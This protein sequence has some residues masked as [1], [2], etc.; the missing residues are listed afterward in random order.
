MSLCIPEAVENMTIKNLRKFFKLMGFEPEND[1]SIRDFF[2]C[3]PETEEYLRDLWADESRYFQENYKS[4]EFDEHGNRIDDPKKSKSIKDHNKRL[5]K[6]VRDAKARYDRFRKR[7]P[8]LDDLKE[9][10][11]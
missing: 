11:I 2:S 7:I 3:I 9:T 1:D 5:E 4:P 6:R 10:Y 8:K